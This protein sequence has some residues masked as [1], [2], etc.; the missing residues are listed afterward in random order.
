MET[1]RRPPGSASG[2]RTAE[3]AANRGV[4]I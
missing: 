4:V 2:K 3:V 1:A